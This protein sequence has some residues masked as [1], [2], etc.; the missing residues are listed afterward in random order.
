[1]VQNR[2]NPVIKNAQDLGGNGGLF[3]TYQ[4]NDG[5]TRYFAND[6]EQIEYYARARKIASALYEA[7]L[8][9]YYFQINRSSERAGTNFNTNNNSIATFH[10]DL[11][12]SP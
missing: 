1:M 6:G 8:R 12:K 7:K 4:G 3:W 11:W 9:P 5:I 10:P 2:S